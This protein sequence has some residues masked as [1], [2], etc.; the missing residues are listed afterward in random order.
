[1]RKLNILIKPAISF[2]LAGLAYGFWYSSN[3]LREYLLLHPLQI[4]TPYASVLH[5]SLP[6][7]LVGTSVFAALSAGLVWFYPLRT[8]Q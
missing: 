1:M 4:L 2:S 8:S 7:C 5:N 6:E 3:L